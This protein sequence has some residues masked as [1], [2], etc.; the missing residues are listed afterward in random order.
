[1]HA[2]NSPKNL[3]TDS[4]VIANEREN[5]R[6]LFRQTPEMVCILKGP[7]HVFEFVNEAHVKALGFDATGRTV[8]DAQPESVEV[9]GILDNVY[10]TGVTAELHEIPIT[11][12]D[13][14][15]YFNLTY[16]ARRDLDGQVNG[17]MILGIE[18]TQDFNSREI[19]KS[20]NRALEMT[21]SGSPMVD[22]LGVLAQAIESYLAQ[23][24]LVSILLLDEQGKHLRHGAAPSLPLKYNQLID[25]LAIGP[26]VGSCGTAAFVNEQ[27]IVDDIATDPLW[28]DFHEL[29]AEH[30]L[31]SCWSNPIR[32]SKGKL[33]GT[34]AIYNRSKSP[35][36]SYDQEILNLINHTIALVIERNIEAKEKRKAEQA[37]T[38]SE[39]LYRSS[40]EQLEQ[41]ITVAKVGFY[42]WNIA[43]NKVTFS[44][45]MA[46][47]WGIEP[48]VEKIEDVL[49]Y[50][51]PEDKARVEKLISDGLK[52]NR[53]FHT[54]YRVR[55][56]DG[57]YEWMDV[58]GQI[59]K[60]SGG[61][62]VR[63]FGTSVIKTE[64]KNIETDLRRARED[65]EKAS[66]AKG[67]FLANM[68]HEIR[69]PLGAIL[70][71][72]DLLK[73]P[74]NT[75]ENLSEY[76]GVIDR[77][78]KQLLRIVDDVLDLSKIE[79]GEFVIESIRF[80]LMDLLADFTSLM[81]FKAREKGLT[82]HL[83][84]ESD[85]PDFIKGDPTRIRQILNNV[86]G[87]AIKFT[88]K[89]HVYVKVGFIKGLLSITVEDTGCGIDTS[90]SL[91][92]FQPFSQADSST[93][94]VYG[95]T[96]LGL[97]LTTRLSKALGGK[98]YLENSRVDVGSTFV[99]VIPLEVLQETKMVST[100]DLNQDFVISE[101]KKAPV[102]VLQ[103]K[104]ILVVDDSPD[105]R[106][107]LEI[108]LKVWGAKVA[109]A[110][111]GSEGVTRATAS[112]FDVILM[113]V[114]MPVMDGHEATQ[115]LRASGYAKPIIALTAHAMK[116][117]RDR[118]LESGFSNFL[119]KP[120]DKDSLLKLL[121]EI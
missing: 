4:N 108:V 104:N 34:F 96:G 60:D 20:Q 87:N 18:I 118:C 97:S 44:S 94:R 23:G 73:N 117:E 41:A 53:P 33:I 82:Y 16:S 119:S 12:G 50:I 5:F 86:V 10:K 78:S 14:L 1:M 49:S 13:R 63:F 26:K 15:R 95:G 19:L 54:E 111:N 30:N 71:F 2:D 109:M 40:E 32:S 42:D 121:T 46:K 74:S 105:N 61:T 55:Q 62:P 72:L 83:K 106:A 100:A 67:I 88:A 66:A 38:L 89:G 36:S 69:T 84:L 79:A 29:A 112:D 35:V 107:L 120:I 11:L 9:H 52:E 51:H 56:P 45:Q 37:L 77:N 17:V 91:R 93:T 7:D 85:L 110:S 70:G 113:D 47:D 57:Q 80:S 43:D 6:N 3:Q 65:A 81:S 39:N 98:F 99:I 8:R 28:A 58:R 64:Q 101:P 92:L 27:V 25:G 76:I 75:S 31:K 114:Q 103:D 48:G 90:T 115:K 102:K 24:A 68:S 59:D 116:E 22:V 21:M